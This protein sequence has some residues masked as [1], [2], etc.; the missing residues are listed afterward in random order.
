MDHVGALSAEIGTRGTASH[1]EEQGARYAAQVLRSQGY[2][3]EEQEFQTVTTF[4][5]TFLIL[6]LLPVLAWAVSWSYPLVGAIVALLAA[7]LFFLELNT[8]EVVSRLLPKATSRNVVAHRPPVGT[9]PRQQVVLVAHVDTSKVALNFSPQM[10]K[11]FRTSFLVM[12]FSVIAVPLLTLLRLWIPLAASW[13]LQIP[14]V[15]YLLITSGFL[16]HREKW[17]RYTDGANDNASGVGIVLALAEQMRQRVTNLDL[18]C[19]ITG[20]EEA[21][22]FGMI[23]FLQQRGEHFRNA[24]FINLDNMGAGTVHFMSGE[25]MFPTWSASPQLLQF[26]QQTQQEHPGL[27]VRQGVYNLMST[28]AL[29]ALARGYQAISFLAVDDAGLLP[30]WHWLSDTYE[31][32]REAT[33]GQGQAFVARLLELIDRQA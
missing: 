29:P 9:E 12:V 22:T 18:W 16:L 30:N 21:G 2:Q 4:S 27:G 3:V 14:F 13:W 1:G 24:Y 11:G 20:A 19:L 6:Y 23:R 7:S 8:V 33:L 10:V 26:C 32:V 28:D 31:N 5:W 25:G 17:N 15:V